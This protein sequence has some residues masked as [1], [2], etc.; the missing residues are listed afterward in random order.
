MCDHVCECVHGYVYSCVQECLQIVCTPH[1]TPTSSHMN[2]HTSHLTHYTHPHHTHL[3]SLPYDFWAT[4]ACKMITV[5]SFLS[6]RYA[7]MASRESLLV[8]RSWYPD[9]CINLWPMKWAWHLGRVPVTPLCYHTHHHSYAMEGMQM[10]GHEGEG[11]HHEGV[12]VAYRVCGC[13]LQLGMHCD[14]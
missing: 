3:F 14:V 1:T 9:S 6:F 7:R 5:Q 8:F 13:G 12:G 10:S 4:L 11:V 2:P